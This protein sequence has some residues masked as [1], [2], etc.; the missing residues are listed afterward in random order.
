MKSNIEN[1]LTQK[2]D[3]NHNFVNLNFTYIVRDSID[4]Q[5]PSISFYNQIVDFLSSLENLK[6]IYI[7]IL[8]ESPCYSKWKS[9]VSTIKMRMPSKKV[10][11]IINSTIATSDPDYKNVNV[12]EVFPLHFFLMK[13]YQRIV[14][15]KESEQSVQWDSDSNKFLF[16]TGKP[17]RSHRIGMMYKFYQ[18]NY[19]DKMT[20]SF[21]MFDNMKDEAKSQLRQCFDVTD[22]EFD[23]FVKASLNDPELINELYTETQHYDGIPYNLQNYD[24]AL[25]SVITETGYNPLFGPEYNAVWITEKTWK[26]IINHLPFIVISSDN[27]FVRKL[28]EYGFKTFDYLYNSL[29]YDE[30]RYMHFKVPM[31][32][33]QV[34]AM[35]MNIK[36]NK[37]QVWEDVQY[38][39]NLLKDIH[40]E[41]MLELASLIDRNSSECVPENL[42]N[43]NKFYD[44][45][46]L[47]NYLR[48]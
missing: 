42:I 5:E 35:Y 30:M 16:F 40:N 31:F 39:Y 47:T 19:F 43:F 9:I 20:W 23:K 45:D 15:N 7:S 27:N 8:Y 29:D 46:K 48:I 33:E 41:Q 36:N 13:D 6:T 1:F 17:N 28:K 37:E 34:D 24:N 21:F 18:E 2:Y 12:D 4:G 26:P 11:V 32:F 22:L 38:N 10:V 14:V 3:P 44:D 25:F